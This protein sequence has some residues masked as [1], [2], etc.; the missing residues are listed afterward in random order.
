MGAVTRVY[1]VAMTKRYFF[2]DPKVHEQLSFRLNTLVGKW[3]HLVMMQ[4][5][6]AV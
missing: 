5:P 4:L 2:S 3:W 1:A 6:P